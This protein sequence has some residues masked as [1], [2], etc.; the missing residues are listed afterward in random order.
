MTWGCPMTSPN[1]RLV[2]VPDMQLDRTCIL[3]FWR[4]RSI[5]TCSAPGESGP[6]ISHAGA[7]KI[8]PLIPACEQGTIVVVWHLTSC[9]FNTASGSLQHCT[10]GGRVMAAAKGPQF[11][12]RDHSQWRRKEADHL[13]GTLA[14][15]SNSENTLNASKRLKLL[16]GD[17]LQNL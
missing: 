6:W 13:T 16:H 8:D 17:L 3:C 4:P 1:Q 14:P 15:Q 2:E 7:S 12:G 11:L 5:S 10:G 9:W